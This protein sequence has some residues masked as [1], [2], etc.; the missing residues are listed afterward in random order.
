MKAIA[1]RFGGPENLVPEEIP[2]PEPAPE[3]VLIGIKAIGIDP[4]D[5]KTRRGG[6]WPVS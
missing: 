1:K 3:E 4:I 2:S 6:E 5:I